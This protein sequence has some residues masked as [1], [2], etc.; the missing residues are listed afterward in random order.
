MIMNTPD[1]SSV[2]GSKSQLNARIS[3]AWN[4][5]K[6]LETVIEH[7]NRLSVHDSI[8]AKSQIK[9]HKVQPIKRDHLEGD[10]ATG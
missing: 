8:V 5:L 6:Q 1:V 2:I 9:A 7:N 10:L 3:Q 4:L